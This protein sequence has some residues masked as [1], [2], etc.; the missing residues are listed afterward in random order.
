MLISVIAVFSLSPTNQ[1]YG[2]FWIFVPSTFKI[3]SLTRQTIANWINSENT[4]FK[5]AC[6]FYVIAHFH[7]PIIVAFASHALAI[8][9]RK[10]FFCVCLFIIKSVKYLINLKTKKTWS[11]YFLCSDECETVVHLFHSIS[12]ITRT[13]DKLI[14]FFKKRKEP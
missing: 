10:I 7:R 8:W 12:W 14:F 2:S 11:Y 13:A 5:S 4:W 3:V 9:S 1:T 6:R